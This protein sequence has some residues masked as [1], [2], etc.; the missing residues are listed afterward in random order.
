MK[1]ILGSNTKVQN[2]FVETILEDKRKEL[3]KR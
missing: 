2:D 3:M 1:T